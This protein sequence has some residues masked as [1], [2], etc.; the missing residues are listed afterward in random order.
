[1]STVIK[2]VYKDVYKTIIR[3]LQAEPKATPSAFR[4]SHTQDRRK[5][6]K[7]TAANPR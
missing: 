1:M 2:N 4:G 5:L 7:T 3:Q 6:S